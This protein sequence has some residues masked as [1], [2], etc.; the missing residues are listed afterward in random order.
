MR[1]FDTSSCRSSRRG[2]KGFDE[3][4][5]ASLIGSRNSMIGVGLAPN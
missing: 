2:P 4:A 3:A 1:S 5:L